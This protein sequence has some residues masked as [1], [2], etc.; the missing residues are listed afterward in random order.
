MKSLLILLLLFSLLFFNYYYPI[1]IIIT[2]PDT[3]H[4][5]LVASS[6][7]SPPPVWAAHPSQTASILDP[8]LLSYSLQQLR[9]LGMI[10]RHFIRKLPSTPPSIPHHIKHRHRLELEVLLD[11]LVY[12][13]H[14]LTPPSA[15][16]LNV[17]ALHRGELHA[18]LPVAVLVHHRHQHR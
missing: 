12:C 11:P 14:R 13:M 2:E 1:N 8:S 3:N 10:R 16:P 4:T 9:E 5:L 6:I 18:V 7:R 15:I 17:L